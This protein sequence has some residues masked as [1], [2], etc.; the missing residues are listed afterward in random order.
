MAA[1]LTTIESLS[2]DGMAFSPFTHIHEYV[3][4]AL[5]PL[6]NKYLRI[7]HH[8]PTIDTKKMTGQVLSSMKSSGRGREGGRRES[9][10]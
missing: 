8:M 5:S 7:A 1:K 9:D 3:L 4:Y 10:K 6:S 2:R